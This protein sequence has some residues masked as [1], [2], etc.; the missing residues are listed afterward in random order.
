ML[1]RFSLYGFLKNQRYFEPYL[2]L[3]LLGQSL[4]FG[5]IGTLVAIREAVLLFSEIPGGIFADI[6]GK[7]K[8]LVISFSFYIL[9]FLAF[10]SGAGFSVFALAMMFYGFA[11]AFR[12]GIHKALIINWLKIHQLTAEKTRYYGYT[13]SWSKLGSAFSI[14]IAAILLY[15][16]YDY[17]LLF[18]FSAIPAI[19]NIINVYSY[20]DELDIRDKKSESD[21]R[22][23]IGQFMGSYQSI[24]GNMRLKVLFLEAMLFE[25]NF[26]VAKDYIQ[27]V[28]IILAMSLAS[29]SDI[30]ATKDAEIAT[31]SIVYVLLFL[32][33]AFG[34]RKAHMFAKKYQ[35]EDEAAQGMWRYL[36]ILS[37]IMLVAMVFDVTL[38]SIGCFVILHFL[39][40]FWRPVLI[41]R[42][43]TETKTDNAATLLSVESQVKS[44]GI[45]VMAPLLGFLVDQNTA[46]ESLV[47][48][49][50][51]AVLGILYGI[52]VLLIRS[53][54]KKS[55][56]I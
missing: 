22:Q 6:Y 17:A 38:V 32:L 20:P 25:G 54:L 18:V 31:I 8:S 56:K 5:Q 34:S 46:T 49:W 29:N 12:T 50:P 52:F 13:R 9:S 53:A 7:R 55:R 10:Y 45:I 47:A 4:S 23:V 33:S 1:F 40:N 39:Q 14:P 19:A 30:L 41:S 15:V 48:F 28:L 26:K 43:A 2:I 11:D 3:F 44:V 42:V 36:I 27:P 24:R 21:F 16:E 51:V 37:S 35:S